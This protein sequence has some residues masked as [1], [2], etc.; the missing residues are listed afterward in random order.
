MRAT[1]DVPVDLPELHERVSRVPVNAAHALKYEAM[2]TLGKAKDIKKAASIASR[3]AFWPE[4]EG[5]RRPSSHL[6]SRTSSASL[7]L[8]LLPSSK[9]EIIRPSIQFCKPGEF[10]HAAAAVTL[11][12]AISRGSVQSN[13]SAGRNLV[14]RQQSRQGLGSRQSRLERQ[15][16]TPTFPRDSGLLNYPAKFPDI[17]QKVQISEED[18]VKILVQC[19]RGLGKDPKSLTTEDVTLGL[20]REGWQDEEVQQLLALGQQKMQ[21]MTPTKQLPESVVNEFKAPCPVPPLLCRDFPG[22]LK[23][24]LRL[25]PAAVMSSTSGHG[26]CVVLLHFYDLASAKL[27]VGHL[28]HKFKAPDFRRCRALREGSLVRILIDVKRSE[29]IDALTE[30]LRYILMLRPARLPSKCEALH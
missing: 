25:L 22:Y 6:R 21:G 29:D 17:P 8:P 1:F 7:G 20:L 28:Q 18:G 16:S 13:R 15:L 3:P 5:M 12:R 24:Q 9:S 23:K 10:G 4:L 30:T 27:A 2:M 19:I 11:N 14:S 26:D